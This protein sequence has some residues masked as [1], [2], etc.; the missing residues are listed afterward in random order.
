MDP[1]AVPT[2]FEQSET[3]ERSALEQLQLDKLRAMLGEVLQHNPFY[4]AKFLAIGVERADDIRTLDDYRRLPFTTRAELSTDQVATPPYGTN[5]TCAPEHYTRIH[6]TSGTTGQR[7][8]WLDTAASWDWWGRCWSQVYHAAGIT[9]ADRIF[10]A[11]SFGPFIGFWSASEG[12]R[13]LGALLIPGGGMSS[14][15]RLDAISENEA[16]VLVSTPTYA[17]HLAEVA[18][19][20]KLDLPQTRIHTTI[21]AGEPGAGLPATRQRLEDAWGARCFDHA[22]AT[23]VGA[24]GFECQERAGLHFNEAEFI[25]EVVDP[26]SGAAADEGE[27]VITNLGRNGMP[28]IRYH[29]GDRVRLQDQPCACG[30]TYQRLDGGV[31]GR[32]DDAF[33][34]R[35]VIFYPSTIENIVR[36]FPQVTEFAV[37][38][39][40]R[41]NL[42]DMDVHIELSGDDNRV[43]DQVGHAIRH[44]LGL[45]ATVQIAAPNTLPRFELKARRFTDH[46]QAGADT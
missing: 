37:D 23:E 1:I 39:H 13:Q 14:E 43:A 6:Q 44:H 30:R 2:V 19:A 32:S 20:Y 3:L 42:D 45:R 31:I 5:L 11:F 21:H 16:T 25:C 17:L 26:A 27:L 36:Q 34:V 10:F 18:A 35:G 4:R 22:G 9:A 29:T 38:I 28:V 12:I 40:R 15:Q 24:W 7:L 46:R 8:R 33:I 41:R